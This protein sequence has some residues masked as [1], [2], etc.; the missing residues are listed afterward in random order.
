MTVEFVA[1]FDF[2]ERECLDR[3]ECLR[4]CDSFRDSVAIRQFL[5]VRGLKAAVIDFGLYDWDFGEFVQDL[6]KK[7]R[8]DP[9]RMRPFYKEEV[10]CARLGYFVR[11]IT[12][13]VHAEEMAEI[14]HSM[15]VRSG[16]EMT[17]GYKLT[18]DELMKSF[19]AA[20]SPDVHCSY[21]RNVWYG[22]FASSE[23]L[24][25]YVMLSRRG[26]WATY[27]K[28]LGH[29]DY[30]KYGIMPALHM[31]IVRAMIEERPYPIRY[32]CYTG[33]WQSRRGDLLRWKI[34]A[35]FRGMRVE[36]NKRG[37]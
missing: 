29:G 16:G 21:H 35:G 17:E 4:L 26:N 28:I 20:S 13:H 32:L 9:F 36:V 25:G 37:E 11:E 10:R 27:N 31:W 22:I 12:P 23:K 34:R 7:A 19:R 2:M 5:D 24:V 8:E 14:N 3:P 18:R 1:R 30:L 33:M 6:R 15:P